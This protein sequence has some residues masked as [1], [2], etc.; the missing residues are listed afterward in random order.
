MLNL[1][2]EHCKERHANV[3]V[4]QVNNGQ[5][6]ERHYCDVCASQFHPFQFDTQEE[7][8]SLQQFITNWFGAPFK[9]NVPNDSQTTKAQL[10]CPTCELTY[11]QFLKKGKFGCGTC[12]STFRNQL[13]PILEKLQAG[14]K[15]IVNHSEK[16]TE[17]REYELEIQ[18]L[19][20]QMN[21]A[22]TAE[23][24]E[25]AAKYRDEIKILETKLQS[26][27]ANTP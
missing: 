9:S 25:D 22:I 14:T 12:Y 7:P 27:G 8:I 4:T 26:G 11:A 10:A 23:R 3:T 17:T 6:M 15:H 21:L 18:K 16:I 24:F 1:I 13:P 2:C 19:R 20:E 5:K